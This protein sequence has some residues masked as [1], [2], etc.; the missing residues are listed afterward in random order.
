MPRLIIVAK[1][2]GAPSFIIPISQV[3]RQTQGRWRHEPQSTQVNWKLSQSLSLSLGAL[4]LDLFQVAHSPPL[5]LGRLHSRTHSVTPQ[6]GPCPQ[7]L[8]PEA[9][10]SLSARLR[11]RLWLAAL[12]CVCVFLLVEVL[13]LLQGSSSM[14]PLPGAFRDSGR[15]EHS[16]PVSVEFYLWLTTIALH[17]N[18]H[19]WYS[20]RYSKLFTYFISFKFYMNFIIVSKYMVIISVVNSFMCVCV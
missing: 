10:L 11:A 3:R 2:R 8:G 17:D 4:S 13:F 19:H 1:L 6:L 20:E 15:Q 14:S 7:M 9:Q 5:W 16:S 18:N 12:C